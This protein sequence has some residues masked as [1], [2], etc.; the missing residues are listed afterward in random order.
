MK[1]I[2]SWLL[3]TVKEYELVVEP[4]NG[5][6]ALHAALIQPCYL[7]FDGNHPLESND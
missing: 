4:L 1:E 3:L 7:R 5:F 2:Y 6:T